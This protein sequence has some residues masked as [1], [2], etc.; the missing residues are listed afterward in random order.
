MTNKLN[1][2]KISSSKMLSKGIGFASALTILALS[3]NG[4]AFADCEP[5]GAYG[6]ICTYTKEFEIDKQVRFVGD[7]DWKDK[8]VGVKEGQKF[9]FKVSIKNNGEVDVDSMKMIDFLPDEIERISGDEL[10]EYWEN[11]ES[12]ERKNFVFEAKVRDVEYDK[13]NFEKCVVNKAEAYYSDNEIGSATAVVCYGDSQPKE[14]PK[15]GPIDNGLLGIL[16]LVST[17]L[18]LSLKSLLKRAK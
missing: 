6:Q 12:G 1:E 15:T 13:K 16:G 10:V 2:N 4:L 3:F 18:G 11:F 14:L 9:E 8:I 17:G 5:D 7:D